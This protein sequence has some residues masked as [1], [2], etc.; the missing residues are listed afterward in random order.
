MTEE[1]KDKLRTI[2]DRGARADIVLKELKDSKEALEKQVFD[3]FRG[4]DVHDAKGHQ[5][6]RFYLKVLDDVFSRFEHFVMTGEEARKELVRM[7][8][9]TILQKVRNG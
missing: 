8:R 9:P 2:Q 5:A 1:R 3:S 4:S 7:K 6:Q